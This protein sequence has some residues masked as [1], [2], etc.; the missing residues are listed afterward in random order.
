MRERATGNLTCKPTGNVRVISAV[1]VS[2][3]KIITDLMG[4]SAACTVMTLAV[5]LYG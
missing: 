1:P 4:W 5:I 3:W 2:E